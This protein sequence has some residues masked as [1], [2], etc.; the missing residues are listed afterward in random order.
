[1]YASPGQLN[2][3]ATFCSQ[4]NALAGTAVGSAIFTS[5]MGM[6]ALAGDEVDRAQQIAQKSSHLAV[7]PYQLGV[8]DSMTIQYLDGGKT[9]T[10][11]IEHID[12][13]DEMKWQLKI[14]CFEINQNAGSAS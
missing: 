11:Q 2:K 10:F 3:Q 4:G 12:D 6:W 5:W 1:M 7:I 9:R 8:L 13:P 14:Y